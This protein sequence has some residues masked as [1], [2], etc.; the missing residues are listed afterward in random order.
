MIEILSKLSEISE[1]APSG[2]DSN[3]KEAETDAGDDKA[4]AENDAGGDKT[5]AKDDAGGDKAFTKDDAG[6]DKAFK[7]D[8]GDDNAFTKDAETPE[9][10]DDN[11]KMSE[12]KVFDKPMSEYDNLISSFTRNE[13]FEGKEHPETGV[14]YERKKIKDA[15]GEETEGVFP[16]FDSTFDAQLPEDLYQ[17]SDKKQSAECNRQLKEA[18]ENDPE[19]AKKFTDDQLEQIKNDDT[20]DGYTWHHNEEAGKMQLVDSE[21][22]AKSGHTGGRAIWGGG[23]ENR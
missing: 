16:V 17:A 12:D 11:G 6:D 21:T 23:Q 14:P 18:V 2:G 13:R 1:A 4:F 8:T 20:P 19:L 5:F 22:H 7:N 3:F 9:K 15:N 10:T